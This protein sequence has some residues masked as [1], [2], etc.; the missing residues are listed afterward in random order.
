MSLDDLKDI[1][2]ERLGSWVVGAIRT[3]TV[4]GIVTLIGLVWNHSAQ[5]AVIEEN[6]QH[7][8][9]T[10]KEN[11][12]INKQAFERLTSAIE[13]HNDIID[14]KLGSISERVSTTIQAIRDGSRNIQ[15]E[16]YP[17]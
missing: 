7:Q 3:A 11:A 4:S 2:Q 16:N 17:Q 5:I 14:A 12:E 1:A 10:I 8:S 15:R 13:R 6:Q 9:A